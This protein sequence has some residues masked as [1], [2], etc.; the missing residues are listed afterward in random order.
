[1]VT[2]HLMPTYDVRESMENLQCLESTVMQLYLCNKHIE[3]NIKL[4][5]LI[6]ILAFYLGNVSTG[7]QNILCI[8]CD[9]GPN[10]KVFPTLGIP[11][12]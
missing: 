9:T 7:Q 5:F 1:M 6:G 11:Q 10:T 2:S 8:Q 4:K 3:L 12:I